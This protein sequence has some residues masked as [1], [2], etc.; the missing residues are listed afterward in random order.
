MDKIYSRKRIKI[1]K[2]KFGNN[3]K[4]NIVSKIIMTMI[5]IIILIGLVISKVMPTIRQLCITSARS[6]GNKICN[7][8]V[9]KAIS[10]LSYDELI[11]YE[12][13]VNGNIVM[14]KANSINMNKLSSEITKIVQTDL[15]NLDKTSIKIPTGSLTNNQFLYGLGPSLKIKIVPTGSVSAQFESEFVTSGIN[16]TMHRIYLNMTCKVYILGTIANISSEINEKVPVAETII[17][18]NV[19]SSYYNLEGLNGRDAL[20]VIED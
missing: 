14:V 7:E 9:S 18:G 12:Q 2:I 13:D 4:N 15:N 20:E 11:T 5:G 6:I 17:V 3:I 10:N 19:P 16:Q 1:F 8:A